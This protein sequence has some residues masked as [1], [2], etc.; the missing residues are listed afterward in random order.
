MAPP[1]VEVDVAEERGDSR[2]N[3]V[4]IAVEEGNTSQQ[5]EEPGSDE[6]SEGVEAVDKDDD[7]VT[8]IVLDH[9]PEDANGQR[10]TIAWTGE[11]GP[12]VE[13]RRRTI[14]LRELQRVQR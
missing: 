11:A 13:E 7:D 3:E 1:A 2:S 6:T 8:V 10:L 14:M 9:S 4:T 12:Q 5:P